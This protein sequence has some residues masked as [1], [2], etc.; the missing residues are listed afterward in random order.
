MGRVAINIPVSLDDYLIGRDPG[1][2]RLEDRGALAG[3]LGTATPGIG[4]LAAA[5]APFQDAHA[6]PVLESYCFS[7]SGCGRRW[8]VGD[9]LGEVL[10]HMRGPPMP[11]SARRRSW[12]RSP[13]ASWNPAPVASMIT[14]RCCRPVR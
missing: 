5:R 9:E 1:V 12:S 6:T 3:I 11:C 13:T 4:A 14:V 2:G 10:Q 7:G 8:G